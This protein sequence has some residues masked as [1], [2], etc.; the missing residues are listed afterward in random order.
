MSGGAPS[1]W[2]PQMAGINQP[3]GDRPAQSMY[4][5]SYGAVSTELIHHIRTARSS[6]EAKRRDGTLWRLHESATSGGREFPYAISQRI[7]REPGRRRFLI[8][9]K[10]R[11]LLVP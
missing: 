4:Y 11:H 6:A 8:K 3:P 1:G 10:N 5:A 9:L 2:R 7:R